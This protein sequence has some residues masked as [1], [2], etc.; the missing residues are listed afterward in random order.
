V[1]VCLSPV[2]LILPQTVSILWHRIGF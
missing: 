2:S 1:S